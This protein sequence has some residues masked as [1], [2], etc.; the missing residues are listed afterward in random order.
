MEAEFPSNSNKSKNT[1]KDDA[2]AKAE[3][4]PVVTGKVIQKK[5][6]FGSKFREAFLGMELK[7][8]GRYIAMDVLF[9]ALRNTIVE[10]TTRGVEKLILGEERPPSRRSAY[11]NGP[12]I[13]YNRPSSGRMG[14]RQRS[15]M[16]NDRAPVVRRQSLA[17][18]VLEHREDAHTVIERLGDIIDKFQVASVAD[19]Y[20]LVNLP[21]TYVDNKWGWTTI[22]YID[23]QQVREGWLLLIPPPEPLD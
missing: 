17:D 8:V 7:S 5:K 12:I 10:A 20:D 23:I 16:Q 18:I 22:N 9:P 21:S 15:Y 1:P 6:G 2:P 11:S 3:I 13:S 14:P 19:L 4:V